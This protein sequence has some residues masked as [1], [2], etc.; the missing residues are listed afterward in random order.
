MSVLAHQ[1][2]SLPEAIGHLKKTMRL[3]TA[4]FAKLADVGFRTLQDIEQKRSERSVQTMGR[5]FAVLGLKLGV[6]RTAPNAP[7][8]PTNKRT[9]GH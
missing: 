7:A 2:W 8:T 4:E 5:I 3:T 9:D 6:V 1:V